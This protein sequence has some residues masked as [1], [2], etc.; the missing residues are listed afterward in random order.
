MSCAQQALP[1]VH[2]ADCHSAGMSGKLFALRRCASE[3]RTP[4]GQNGGSGKIYMQLAGW[5]GDMA[6]LVVPSWLGPPPWPG[7]GRGR[8]RSLQRLQ[9]R[10][11]F[12]LMVPFSALLFSTWSGFSPSSFLALA[13]F[14]SSALRLGQD[15]LWHLL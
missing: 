7:S 9:L 13:F 10:R 6:V 2:V 8:G 12:S 5:Q 11:G 15:G 1:G 4:L 14:S 3:A